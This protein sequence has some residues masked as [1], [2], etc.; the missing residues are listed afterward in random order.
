MWARNYIHDPQGVYDHLI[1]TIRHDDPQERR[2]VLVP[3]N[4]H[5]VLEYGEWAVL[6]AMYNSDMY[7]WI[8]HI[9]WAKCRAHE[10]DV[11]NSNS[12]T[13]KRYQ[14]L[15]MECRVSIPRPLAQEVNALH[16]MYIP[17]AMYSVTSLTSIVWFCASSFQPTLCW[18]MYVTLLMLID[19]GSTYSH[20]Q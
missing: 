19:A 5:L 1:G 7:V 12:K 6:E 18:H 4:V 13:I 15:N 9:R 3:L 14:H 11:P 16:P 20:S 10:V 17:T 2:M 8:P